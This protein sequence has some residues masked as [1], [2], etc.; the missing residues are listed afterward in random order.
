VDPTQTQHEPSEHK[1][2]L[3]KVLS[4]YPR[5]TEHELMQHKTTQRNVQFLQPTQHNVMKPTHLIPMYTKLT[6][7]ILSQNNPKHRNTT[8][9][10]QTK[11]NWTLPT[12]T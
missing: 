3:P 2:N 10:K 1:L 12:K 11:G 9:P 7:P 4:I 6:Y 8:Q 5:P